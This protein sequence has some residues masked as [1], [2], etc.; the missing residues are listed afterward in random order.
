MNQVRSGHIIELP[1]EETFSRKWPV[2]IRQG[3][4]NWLKTIA[5]QNLAHLLKGHPLAIFQP[6]VSRQVE[7]LY[8]FDQTPEQSFILTLS[9]GHSEDGIMNPSSS[10]LCQLSAEN[11]FIAKKRFFKFFTPLAGL[12]NQGVIRA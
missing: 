9:G 10:P 7:Y 12:L 5:P 1:S 2:R 6:M 4:I 11:I 3:L 8:R